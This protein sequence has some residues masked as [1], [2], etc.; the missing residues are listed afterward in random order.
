MLKPD[1]TKKSKSEAL[2]HSH[3]LISFTWVKNPTGLKGRSLRHTEWVGGVIRNGQDRV[4]EIKEKKEGR[5]VMTHSWNQEALKERTWP[6]QY[7]PTWGLHFFDF[8]FFLL[9]IWFSLPST[10]P[11]YCSVFILHQGSS[12]WFLSTL[13][14]VAA[15]AITIK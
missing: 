15:A 1:K 3:V 4:C 10:G 9:V 6:A 12:V 13:L 5:W 11:V 8:F 14:D 2:Y 7:L